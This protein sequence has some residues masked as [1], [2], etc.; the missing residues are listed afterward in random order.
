[1]RISLTQSQYLFHGPPGTGKSS[2][3]FALAGVFG[4]DIYCL[5]LNDKGLTENELCSLF[6]DLPDRCIVLLEDIDSAGLKRAEEVEKKEE[7]SSTTTDPS[8]DDAAKAAAE[9]SE[10]SPSGSLSLSAL[11]NVIDGAASH[12]VIFQPEIIYMR[13]SRP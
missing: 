8:K 4:L 5:S 7:S 12:E 3:S 10:T 13:G 1:M 6:D 2:L 11:L 9:K